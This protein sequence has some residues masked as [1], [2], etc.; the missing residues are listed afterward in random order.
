M[1]SLERRILLALALSLPA[2]PGAAA[3]D[4]SAAF[5]LAGQSNMSGRGSLEALEP[6]ERSEVSAVDLY[7]NDGKWKKAIEP[8]D[9]AADQV[10]IVSED[11]SAAVG[12]GLFFARAMK[13]TEKT[14]VAL[15]P[16]AKGGS[17][18]GRWKRSQKRDTLY[19]S[20]LARIREADRR[21]AGIL[22]Y[23]GETDADR[24][25]DIAG[26]WSEHFRALVTSFRRDLGN[27]RLP[28]VFVQIA[29]RP[30]R[31]PDRN[32]SWNI[33]QGQQA[34]FTLG[35]TAMV[36]AVGLARNPDELHLSTTGQRELGASLAAAMQRL[37]ED[38]CR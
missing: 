22:W 20:C 27:P 21:V 30:T 14:P 4:A 24:S 25:A 33:V 36:S 15:I 5:V 19:G 31:K 2:A 6:S 34:E 29:E 9:S 32:L 18:I 23:Q 1:A 26:K 17:S 13:P 10:D 28:V 16:C 38:G 3:K 7:G 37:I 11:H 12:P 8:I 35:C